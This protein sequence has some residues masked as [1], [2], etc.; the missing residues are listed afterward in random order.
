M[1]IN[2]WLD[3]TG[4]VGSTGAKTTEDRVAELTV[5]AVLPE[6]FAEL[7]VMVAVPGAAVM[8]R[9]LLFTVAADIFDEFQR[10]CLD[11]SNSVPSE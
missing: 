3:P 7:A 5:S 9:P 1:A 11:R 10:T 6:T 8:A 4:K 2:C